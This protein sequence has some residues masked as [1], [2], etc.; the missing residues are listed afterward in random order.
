MSMRV[1]K[2]E[3]VSQRPG[4]DREKGSKVSNSKPDATTMHRREVRATNS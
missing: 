3:V 2:D 4:R 1:G